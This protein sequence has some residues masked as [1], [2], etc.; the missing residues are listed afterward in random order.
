MSE[1]QISTLRDDIRRLYDL[2]NSYNL[3]HQTLKTT[4]ELSNNAHQVD[5]IDKRVAVLE[6]IEQRR[7]GGGA[8]IGFL[9]G[10]V[11]TVVMSVFVWWISKR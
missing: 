2:V 6:G 9:A 3:V 8:V 10:A 11:G 5:L 7:M 1:D 4:V